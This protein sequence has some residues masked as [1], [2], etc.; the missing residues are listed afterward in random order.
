MSVIIAPSVLSAD[1][2][3]LGEEVRAVDG[4]VDLVMLGEAGQR[5]PRRLGLGPG[6]LGSGDAEES[7]ALAMAHRQSLDGEGR[8]RAGTEPDDHAV[9]HE[10]DRSLGRGAL[11]CIAFRLARLYLVRHALASPAA[12]DSRIA[13]M[14]AA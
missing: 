10:L 6:T 2:T 14:A 13:A 5:D 1:F 4:K 8:G 9:G 3:R 12:A 11:Q 7:Q